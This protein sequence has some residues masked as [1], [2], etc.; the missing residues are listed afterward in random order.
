ML[1]KEICRC[2]ESFAPLSWQENY[3]NSGLI[4]GCS[5]DEVN[6]ALVC[7]DITMEIVEEALEK[8]CD[9]IISHHPLIFKG[10]KALN[11]KKEKDK[12]IIRLIKESIAV[13]AAH[14]NIDNAKNGVSSILAKKIG[15]K[16]LVP[17]HKKGELLAKLVC[18]CPIDYA[19][20]MRNVLFDAGAGKIGNYD[21]CSF[22]IIGDGSFRAGEN[23]NP[24]VGEKGKM[25]YEKEVKIETIIER[26][27][28]RGIIEA[29]LE[30]HPYEEVAYDIYPLS[31]EN[32][33]VGIGVIGKLDEEILALDFLKKLKKDINIK[34]IR[35]NY[36]EN[37]K[38]KK[39]AVCGG[40]GAEYIDIAI[41]SNADL[42]ISADLKYHDYEHAKNSILLADIGHYESEQ[43]T[44]E[45]ISNLLIKKFPTFAV[46][47]AKTNT[48]FIHYL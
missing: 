16:V 7:V 32:T 9:I 21:S 6:K 48:N 46:E 15:L 36:A 31:N 34:S 8:N 38:I 14:T 26:N 4:L 33:G 30:A 19:E 27:Q 28:Q 39:I 1:I 5:S 2:I 44:K 13:Y 37:K 20:N 43:F 23:T 12:I 17:M 40:S 3:D 29:M 11:N 22:N 25:H 18:F 42:Y 47:N 24:F 45:L 10:I 41:S 35:H